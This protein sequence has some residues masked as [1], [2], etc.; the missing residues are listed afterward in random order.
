MKP[1]LNEVNSFNTEIIKIG[2]SLGLTIPS[3][4]AKFFGIDEKDY[5]KVRFV[6]LKKAEEMGGGL[7]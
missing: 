1:V 4:E 5:V 7:N 2:N 6:I 3:K